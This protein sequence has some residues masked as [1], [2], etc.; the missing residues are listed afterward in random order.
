M[1]QITQIFL[2]DESPTLS[3]SEVMKVLFLGINCF[4]QFFGFFGISLKQR[5]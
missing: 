1:K 2:E 3:C 5:N 4:Q